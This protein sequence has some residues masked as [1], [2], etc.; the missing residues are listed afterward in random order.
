METL[1]RLVEAYEADHLP[2]PLGH[3]LA[4]LRIL[5]AE[6]G[7]AADDLREIGDRTTVD[8]ILAGR[9][10]LTALQIRLLGQRFHVSPAV[11]C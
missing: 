4:T 1:G 11:F 3:P 8:A 9:Q 5:M 7:L 10:E 6:Q 2:E